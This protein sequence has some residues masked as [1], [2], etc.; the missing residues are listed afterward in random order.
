MKVKLTYIG[1]AIS[2][3]V[4]ISAI[5][6]NVVQALGSNLVPKESG[7]MLLDEAGNQYDYSA[8]STI[9]RTVE[10]GYQFSNN[11]E[12]WV[13]PAVPVSVRAV[14]IDSEDAEELRPTSVKVNVFDDGEPIGTVTLNA[15]NGWVKK[16]ENVP[17][18]HT[19]TITAPDVE[20]YSKQVIGTE[21]H[22]IVDPNP[23]I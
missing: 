18:S 23:S 4:D 11:G 14:W 7:F 3:D 8:Y 1:E 12:I 5:K 2:Y 13:E 17:V 9:Y 22:Y 15:K 16:Y 10:G 19:Y 21:V 20:N 6:A